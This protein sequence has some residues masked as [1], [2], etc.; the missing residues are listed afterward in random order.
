MQNGHHFV[1]EIIEFSLRLK[2]RVLRKMFG[3]VLYWKIASQIV[4]YVSHTSFLYIVL[5]YY[6]VTIFKYMY[7]L[8]NN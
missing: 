5:Y 8:P 3:K 2:V 7:E 1:L 6:C 4:Y